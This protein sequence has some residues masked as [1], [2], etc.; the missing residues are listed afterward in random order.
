MRY[1]RVYALVA[2]FSVALYCNT[3]SADFA[4]DDNF[5]VVRLAGTLE[6]MFQPLSMPHII[7]QINNG[8]VSANTA[9]TSIFRHD[10]W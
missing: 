6:A 3:W 7:L 9:F 4:F 2:A 10:F 5:A 1:K 8:D